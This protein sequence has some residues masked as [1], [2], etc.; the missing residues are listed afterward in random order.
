MDSIKP[1]LA[2]CDSKN[3]G[4]R[5]NT[6]VF[7]ISEVSKGT[8]SLGVNVKYD[9]LENFLKSNGIDVV[10]VECIRKGG[11]LDEDKVR[12]KTMKVVVKAKDHE[13]RHLPVQSRSQMLQS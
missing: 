4:A 3:V 6:V 8:V 7:P 5:T 9:E 13:P 11:L 10:K 2:L 1:K 12:S